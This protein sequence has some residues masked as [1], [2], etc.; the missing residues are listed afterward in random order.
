LLCGSLEL[1]TKARRWRKV[2]GGGIR[3]VGLL[4][5]A[6]IYALENNINRLN[7]DHENASYMASEI[8]KISEIIVVP[9]LVHTNM[10]YIKRPENYDALHK[11]LQ[12]RNVILANNH[13]SSQTIRFVTHLDIT[14][15]DI[16]FALSLIK[17][18]YK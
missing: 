9:N 4:A 15:N 16:D 14:R 6:G 18:F 5:A 8:S 13:Y 7:K 10:F 3:Q 11:Y 1:I 2:L 12:Q 17:E